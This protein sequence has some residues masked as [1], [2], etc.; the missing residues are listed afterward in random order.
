MRV[1][2]SDDA[3][4]YA[5]DAIR[6]VTKLKDIAGETFNGE[7]LVQRADKGFRRLENYTVIGRVRDGAATG[8]G[9]K[10]RAPS[11]T[12]AMIHRIVMQISTAPAAPCRESLGEHAHDCVKIF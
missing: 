3:G 9:R 1:F 2:D 6:S 5:L 7:I 8:D 11:R 12:Q 10:S 4:A